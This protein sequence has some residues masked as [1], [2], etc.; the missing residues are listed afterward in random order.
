MAVLVRRFWW[1]ITAFVCGCAAV[2]Y[3]YLRGWGSLLDELQKKGLDVAV[4]AF[5]GGVIASIAAQL[6]VV[7]ELNESDFRLDEDASRI[8]ISE[9][10]NATLSFVV[11]RTSTA[12]VERDGIY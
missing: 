10:P 11:S 6:K 1:A 7:T 12:L 3:G 4:G 8:T 2:L 9:E 5:A